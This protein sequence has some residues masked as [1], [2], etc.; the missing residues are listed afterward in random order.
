MGGESLQV[1]VEKSRHAKI[2][3]GMLAAAW[4]FEQ[5]GKLLSIGIADTP[6]LRL[7]RYTPDVASSL[8]ERE[9]FSETLNSNLAGI[10]A[11][12]GVSNREVRT[13]LLLNGIEIKGDYLYN[14]IK[15]KMAGVEQ[16]VANP[17]IEAWLFADDLAV[18]KFAKGAKGESL[19]NRL[20]LPE[21]IQDTGSLVTKV[22]GG[23]DKALEVL[24]TFD[25]SRACARCPSL[26]KFLT[27]VSEKLGVTLPE[28]AEA[29]A[30]TLNRDVF[31]NLID[32]VTEPDRVMFRAADGTV[33]TAAEMA[34]EVREGS[35]LGREYAADVLRVA[36]DWLARRAERPASSQ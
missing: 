28:V 15:S 25:I 9:L 34:R 3:R 10:F 22:F 2:V 18:Q 7:A 29:H 5:K 33:F 27:M 19:V 6:F 21:Q 24:Q 17:T 20:P 26:H 35:E 31:S 12:R 14:E 4:P 32:E 30:R 8:K 11:L 36:R 23:L 13:I 16:C 1:L